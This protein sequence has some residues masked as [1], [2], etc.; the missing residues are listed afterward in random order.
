M[1]EW[2]MGIKTQQEEIRDLRSCSVR[3]KVIVK[4]KGTTYKEVKD[5]NTAPIFVILATEMSVPNADKSWS[6]N[7]YAVCLSIFLW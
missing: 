2:C 5:E 3:A 4:T 7:Y 1:Q 6:M